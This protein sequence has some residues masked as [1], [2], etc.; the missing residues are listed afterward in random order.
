MN[1]FK[2]GR[3]ERLG[4]CLGCREILRIDEG[5]GLINDWLFLIVC[6]FFIIGIELYLYGNLNYD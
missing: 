2:K 1:Y 6:I 5:I 3:G 4:I